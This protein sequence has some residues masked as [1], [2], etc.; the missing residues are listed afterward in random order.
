MSKIGDIVGDVCAR[1]LPVKETIFYGDPK[2]PLAICTLSDIKLLKKINQSPLISCVS[3]AGRLFTE[4]DGIDS[5]VKY[6][7]SNQSVKV[8]ILCGKEVWGHK[9]G[10]SLIQ[11]HSNGINQ[12]R[13]IVGANSPQ[14]YLKCSISEIEYFRKNIK[15]LDLIGT[16]DLQIIEDKI[17]EFMKAEYKK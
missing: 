11:L 4:N 8:L 3:I 9:S 5:L 6:L 17:K 12:D 15:I 16:T 2:S 13:K 14:P 10:H 1:I 7:E